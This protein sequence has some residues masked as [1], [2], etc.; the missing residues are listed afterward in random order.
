LFSHF[1]LSSHHVETSSHLHFV[2][3]EKWTGSEESDTVNCLLKTLERLPKYCYQS[4]YCCLIWDLPCQNMNCK[5]FHE[6]QKIRKDKCY[7]REY[8]LFAPAKLL[9][10]WRQQRPSNQGE[11]N[12]SVT[13][14]NGKPY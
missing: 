2:P 5:M 14:E 8:T 7:H 11:L 12:L 3:T 9:H 6:Q 4:V 10:N 13:G 1:G